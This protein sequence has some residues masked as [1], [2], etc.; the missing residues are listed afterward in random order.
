MAHC[1]IHEDEWR[2]CAICQRDAEREK[3]AGKNAR[4]AELEAEVERLK[5]GLHEAMGWNWLDDDM[6][7]DVGREMQQLLGGTADKGE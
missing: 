5:K 1:E 6:P 2:P 3:N 7:V 4:I